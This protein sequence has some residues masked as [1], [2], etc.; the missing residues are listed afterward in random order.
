MNAVVKKT[1]SWKDSS[2]ISFGEEKNRKILDKPLSKRKYDIHTK[3][4]KARLE[5]EEL[6]NDVH[7][8]E[9]ETI[10][11]KDLIDNIRIKTN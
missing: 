1:V 2:D 10:L 4:Y 5:K 3:E 8:N 7:T 9:D 11:E 6:I